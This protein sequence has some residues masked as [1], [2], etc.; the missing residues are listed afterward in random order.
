MGMY[1]VVGRC[2]GGLLKRCKAF[3]G[4]KIKP[5]QLAKEKKN[6]VENMEKILPVPSEITGFMA[7]SCNPLL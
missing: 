3:I 1:G 7:G 6:K 5:L 2:S 4:V